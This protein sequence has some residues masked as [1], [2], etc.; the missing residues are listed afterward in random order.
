M[1]KIILLCIIFFETLMLCSA[2]LIPERTYEF[3]TVSG[4]AQQLNIYC[5]KTGERPLNII[6]DG[7]KISLGKNSITLEKSGKPLTLSE[8]PGL[9]DKTTLTAVFFVRNFEYGTQTAFSI[10]GKEYIN[11]TDFSKYKPRSEIT[12]SVPKGQKV[13]IASADVEYIPE[14]KLYSDK[15]TSFPIYTTKPVSWFKTNGRIAYY[16]SK[17][18]NP[19]EKISTSDS[20]SPQIFDIGCTVYAEYNGKILGFIQIPGMCA[21]Y[22]RNTNIALSNGEYTRTKEIIPPSDHIPLRNACDSL[23]INISYDPKKIKLKCGK[24]TV[25]LYE[26]KTYAV[27]NNKKISFNQPVVYINNDTA[28][29]H[30]NIFLMLGCHVYENQNIVAVTRKSDIKDIGKLPENMILIDSPADTNQNLVFPITFINKN[31]MTSIDNPDSENINAIYADNAEQAKQLQNKLSELPPREIFVISKKASCIQTLM[32][33]KHII[34]GVLDLRGET[35]P[36]KILQKTLAANCRTALLD[37]ASSAYYLSKFNVSVWTEPK[38]P[39]EFYQNIIGGAVG[40]ITDDP[41][42]SAELIDIFTEPA[43]LGKYVLYGHRGTAVYDCENTVSAAKKAISVGADYI[44]F[45][46]WQTKDKKAVVMHDGTTG[47]ICEKDLIIKESTLAELRELYAG[48]E[49]IPTLKEYLSALKQYENVVF[50]I[51]IKGGS[52]ELVGLT[53]KT[54]QELN[55]THRA[56]ISSFDF[57]VQKVLHMTAPYLA[58]TAYSSDIHTEIAEIYSAETETNAILAGIKEPALR[59]LKKRGERRG[60]TIDIDDEYKAL[61]K[62]F[63]AYTSYVKNIPHE[64]SVTKDTVTVLNRLGEEITVPDLEKICPYGVEMY[65]CRVKRINKPDY[66]IYGIENQ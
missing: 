59:E 56:H 8:Y 36:E 62:N 44:E 51:E 52:T 26:N 30:K 13:T 21:A 33:T 32:K 37:N 63:D 48:T 6:K 5:E 17:P 4:F 12:I 7:Y 41:Q 39:K 10:D 57:S 3:I 2:N 25:Y 65:R 29:V 53:V 28:A 18:L 23:K 27:Y 55:L 9:K 58:C 20:Y 46:I 15:N 11:F 35:R 47:R 14:I 64:I 50:N 60:V 54:L 22:V 19:C 24:N 40:I 61:G 66:Y 16:G 45:D 1:K 42:K 31:T 38:T 49:K 43:S 34:Y